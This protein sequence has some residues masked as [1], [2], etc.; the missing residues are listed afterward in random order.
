MF[1]LD[2]D[3]QRA[4]DIDAPFLAIVAGAGAGKTRVLVERVCRLLRDGAMPERIL[5]VT[6]TPRR[7]RGAAATRRSRDRRRHGRRDHRQHVSRRG[8]RAAPG[9]PRVGAAA[10]GL[11]ALDRPGG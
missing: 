11:G 5:T 7:G 4:V 2:A 6:F 1:A 10:T 9:T 3:Q 8:F